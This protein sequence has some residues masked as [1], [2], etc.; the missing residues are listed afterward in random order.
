M[1]LL[2]GFFSCNLQLHGS[3]CLL[4]DPLVG[5]QSSSLFNGHSFRCR[6]LKVGMEVK[7]VWCVS[8]HANWL[9][10]GVAVGVAY[11]KKGSFW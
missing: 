6:R 5:S 2:V 7:H 11:C 9:K 3:L 4:V 1:Y 8:V 10:G